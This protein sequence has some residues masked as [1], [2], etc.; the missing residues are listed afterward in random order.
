MSASDTA[1]TVEVMVHLVRAKAMLVSLDGVVA[2][3]VWVPRS[4]ILNQDRDRP[5]LAV[6]GAALDAYP[7]ALTIPD[8]LASQKGLDGVERVAGVDDLFGGG[9]R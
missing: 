7:A 6:R 1:V 4:E 3:A 8:W 2:R 5:G 9:M